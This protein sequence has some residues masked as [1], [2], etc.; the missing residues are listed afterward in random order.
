MIIDGASKIGKSYLM[1]QLSQLQRRYRNTVFIHP[2][3]KSEEITQL[4]IVEVQQRLI[5]MY[6]KITRDYYSRFESV[7]VYRSIV[8]VYYYTKYVFRLSKTEYD[9]D[10]VLDTISLLQKHNP[11][12][13]FLKFANKSSAYNMYQY[14]KSRVPYKDIFFKTVTQFVDENLDIQDNLEKMYKKFGFNV[15]SVDT[16]ITEDVEKDL[17][18]RNTTIMKQLLVL[19]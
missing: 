9:Y 13:L 4:P 5:D 10:K 15:I 19:T 8:G 2:Q 17:Q 14:L 11:T 3:L 12:V 16:H 6:H 1:S 18:E 7:V